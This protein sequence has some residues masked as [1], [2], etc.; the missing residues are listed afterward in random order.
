MNGFLCK[1]ARDITNRDNAGKEIFKKFVEERLKMGNLLPWDTI[2]RKLGTFSQSN[3]AFELKSG[4]K[5][6]KLKEE[7]GLLQRF[8]I[9]ARS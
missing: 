4:D 3:K 5:I 9:A 1:I 2:K 7:R 6:I 8:I